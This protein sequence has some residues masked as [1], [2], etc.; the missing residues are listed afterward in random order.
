MGPARITWNKAIQERVGETSSMLSQIKGVK[1]MGLTDFFYN[2]LLNS[3][4]AELKLSTRYRWL[5]VQINGF[6]KL[7]KAC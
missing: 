3:R 7:R 2:R 6:G 5:L 4:S 1:M